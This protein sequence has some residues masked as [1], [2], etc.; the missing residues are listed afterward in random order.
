MAYCQW[1][2]LTLPTE[3]QFEYASRSGGRPTKFPWGNGI[4]SDG[5]EMCNYFQGTFPTEHLNRD[6]FLTTSPVKSFPPNAAGLYDMSGNVWEWCFDLYDGT[7][8]AKS[9]V[10]NPQGPDKSFDPS[11]LPGE[12][13]QVKRVQRGGSFLCNVNNC[14]GYRC[15]A[16]MR[17][18]ET[19]STFHTGFRGVLNPQQ[20]ET[21]QKQQ[22]AIADWRASKQNEPTSQGR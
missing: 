2:G 1:A 9:P 4:T 14:T 17:A 11:G 13:R 3:A 19:S 20:L 7:Y 18:E 5:E 12:E 21:F 6:G 15:G 16:R 10:R 22:Q 8:Y